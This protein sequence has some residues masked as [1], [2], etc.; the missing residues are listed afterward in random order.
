MSQQ[1]AAIVCLQVQRVQNEQLAV[2]SEVSR[3][4]Q[5]KLAARSGPLNM[6]S[7]RQHSYLGCLVHFPVLQTPKHTENTSHIV[8]VVGCT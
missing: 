4:T 6:Y 7:S 5:V 2:L 1:L 3:K 8:F